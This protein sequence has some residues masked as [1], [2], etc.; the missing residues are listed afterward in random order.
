MATSFAYEW[1]ETLLD[2]QNV[3][4]KKGGFPVLKNCTA[5]IRDVQRPGHSQGQITG[6]LG[7]SG[8]GKTTLFEVLSGLRA[9]DEGVVLVG[10]KQQPVKAGDVGVVAQKYPLLEHRTVM[11]NLMFAGRQAGKNK[12][13]AREA[14]EDKLQE[15]GLLE[16]KDKYPIQLS[17]GQKQRVAI[18]Q[19]LICSEHFII[20]DEP[21]SGLDVVAK[22]KVSELIVKVAAQNELNTFI[23]VTHDVTS[24]VAIS[25]TIWLMG[26]DRDTE[27]KIIP[28]ARIM[29][30]IDLIER[31]ICWH[32]QAEFRPEATQLINEIKA[33]FPSL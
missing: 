7:P 24:A 30:V 11:D 10:Q 14:A 13:Y 3:S 18:A 15:F 17:G 8:I 25:D 20:M 4:V 28:G 33:L 26:R 2:V 1:K 5:T 29:E 23:I 16:H 31:N 6:L 12:G 27:G 19:Q 9:P 22:A 32:D 21:F